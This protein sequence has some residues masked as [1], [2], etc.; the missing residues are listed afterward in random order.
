ML[1]S[2]LRGLVEASP[3]QRVAP[4]YAPQGEPASADYTKIF[5][6][7]QGIIRA[8]W[9]EPAPPH[10]AYR[11]RDVFLVGFYQR[12]GKPFHGKDF[13]LAKPPAQD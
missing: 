4:R 5:Y 6:D 2:F 9:H 13:S 1:C 11:R 10:P 7:L 8:S 3:A 12:D